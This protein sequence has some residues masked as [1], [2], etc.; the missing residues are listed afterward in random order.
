[1]SDFS[2]PSNPIAARLAT[3]EPCYIM[4]VRQARTTAIVGIVQATGHQGF[5][6]DLQ[7][8]TMSADTAA[9]LCHAGL[10]AGLTPLVRLPGPDG[11]LCELM[12]EAG[13]QG[14]ILPDVRTAAEA[15]ALATWCRFPPRGERSTVVAG[16]H[17][18]FAAP[19]QA[20]DRARIEAETLALAMLESP[21]AIEAAEEIAGVDGIDILFIGSNDLTS[22]MGIPG[23]YRH[24]RVQEAYRNAIAAAAKHGKQVMVGGIRDAAIVADYVEAGAARCFVTGLDTAML[25]AGAAASIAGFREV[26]G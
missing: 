17:T 13:A 9:Q 23:Q 5:Y 2:T 19:D 7:Y 10:L 15:R 26:F 18:R 12:L 16:P 22:A 1:M 20:A 6:L 24:P 11:A 4:A 3:G 8:A 25:T 14:I 21:E